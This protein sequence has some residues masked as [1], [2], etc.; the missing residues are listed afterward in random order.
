MAGKTLDEQIRVL[1]KRR[2]WQVDRDL[3]ALQ[4]EKKR[5]EEGLKE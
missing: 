5:L 2:L 3:P 1:F 4:E